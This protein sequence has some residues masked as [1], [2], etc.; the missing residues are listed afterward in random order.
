[1]KIIKFLI[2][3]VTISFAQ[4]TNI[5]YVKC[6]GHLEY[7][8]PIE[9][10]PT[11]KVEQILCR[12]GYVVGYDYD[13]KQPLWASYHITRDSILIKNKRSNKFVEDK[14]VPTEYRSTLSDYKKSG[15]D[16]GHISPNAALDFTI[17][18]M[19]ETFL[20][21]NISPQI[22]GFNR[23][24]WKHLETYVRKWGVLRGELY[25]T[26][27]SLFE[28]DRGY[29][30]NK[31]IIP[32]HYYKVIFDPINKDSIAF[33]MPHKKLKKKDIANYIVS[34]DEVES[35]ASL[36][37]NSMIDDSFE[38]EIESVNYQVLWKFK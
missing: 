1:M 9:L 21:S 6:N 20:L 29:I 13:T 37:F 34:V 2:L 18:S 12:D 15:Y 32:S 11:L 4:E 38:E 16:R 27:G 10:S 36:D 28:E 22:G 23:Q 8:A 30:G 7:G 26:T 31:V 25:I 14:E 5:E 24:G 17:K 3:I 35:R 33:I 19:N